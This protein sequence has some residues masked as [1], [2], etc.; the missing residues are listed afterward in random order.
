M[1]RARFAGA[2]LGALKTY[3]LAVALFAAI[4]A[5]LLGG[6]NSTDDASRTEQ[7]EMLRNN[8]RRAVVS[9]YA[10]EGS[11]PESIDYIT[12]N[13]GVVIDESKFRVFYDIFGSNIMPNFDVLPVG[14]GEVG[15]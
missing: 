9:C 1:D 14:D 13:Y 10:I 15:P 3:G 12:Q 2:A 6:L 5:I 4:A 7:L 11:Y 8:I